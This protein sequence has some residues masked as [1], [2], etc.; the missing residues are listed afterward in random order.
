MRKT[1]SSRRIDA[2]LLV[3]HC[4]VAICAMY[5]GFFLGMTKECPPC[6]QDTVSARRETSQTQQPLELEQPQRKGLAHQSNFYSLFPPSMRLL[7]V[8]M[9]RV[10]R[11]DFAR[12]FDI[13]V[14]MNPSTHGNE[15]V[16]LLYDG[17]SLPPQD[18][19]A[20][21][22]AIPLY[23]SPEEATKNCISLSMILVRANENRQ[24]VALVGQ[25][26]S[27]NVHKWMRFSEEPQRGVSLQEPLRLVS[28]SH[29]AL[30]NSFIDVPKRHYVK[31]SFKKLTEY[32]N[33][34]DEALQKLRP[35]A[36]SVAKGNKDKPIIVMVCN[37]GQSE[38]FINF[39]CSARSKG[40]DTSRILLFATDIETKE[41]AE[42]MGI[43]S[44]YDEKVSSLRLTS[45][46]YRNILRRRVSNVVRILETCQRAQH[47]SMATWF[48]Q[49]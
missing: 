22:D 19:V 39:V 45:P 9:G 6:L 40:L 36:R 48:F 15:E 24:C 16:L 34:L 4:M 31:H 28:R 26:P 43:A 35:V 37:H 29:S 2:T 32:L 38:L 46:F 49:A 10:K 42:A 13:G 14:P 44:F 41:L 30:M 47:K 20:T 3:S 18:A 33:G 25:W 1:T 7:F 21:T 17:R 27:P 11:D 12:A 5:I 23:A 8:G